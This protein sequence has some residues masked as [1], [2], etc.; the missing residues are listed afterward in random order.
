[1]GIETWWDEVRA[2]VR[3]WQGAGA[4]W[5]ALSWCPGLGRLFNTPLKPE[6]GIS[7]ACPIFALD[8]GEHAFT[9]EFGTDRVAYADTVL[10]SL[11]WGRIAARF[12]T[13]NDASGSDDATPA[14]TE[15]MSVK[16]LKARIDRGDESVLVLDVRHD[17]DR[18][19]YRWRIMEAGWRDSFDV[20]KWAD[21]C[22]KDKTIVAYCMYGFWVSQK[23]A[24]DLRSRGLDARSLSGG[25]AAWRAMGLPSTAIQTR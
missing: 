12:R 10:R 2:L 18:E 7:G 5:I 25:I 16:E 1:G 11:H 9:A 13:A 17:D 24:A 8:M 4:G 19:R 23:V 6:Q 3:S 21:R 20:E 22:P 14:G 15:Q